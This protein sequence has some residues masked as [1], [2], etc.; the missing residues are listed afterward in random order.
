MP[1]YYH[2]GKIVNTHGIRGE[3]RVL[4]TTDFPE[5][6]FAVGKQLVVLTNPAT[7][8]TVKSVREHKGLTM[9]TFDGYDDINAVLP[10]KGQELAVTDAQLHPLDEGEYYYRDIIG[11]TVIDQ[12]NVELGRVSEILS[13]GPNDVWV[14]PRK[15]KSDIL[16]P[17]LNSVVQSID[18]ETKTAHVDV[19]EGLIV[20]A[21]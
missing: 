3:V 12:N 15:G 20:D 5:E 9:L 21:D 14:I 16:L 13:P 1:E 10:F 11:L 4:V 18:L 7:T 8:V 17:F 6:R 19:P 2:V